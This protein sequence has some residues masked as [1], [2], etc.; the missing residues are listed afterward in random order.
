MIVCCNKKLRIVLTDNHAGTAGRKLCFSLNFTKDRESVFLIA[1]H[2]CNG[3]DR[4][5]SILCHLRNRLAV[6]RRSND[7][8]RRDST[9]LRLLDFR[10]TALLLFFLLWLPFLRD[11]INISFL[12]NI[13]HANHHPA[14]NQS[15]EQCGKNHSNYSFHD[16][17]PF[18]R[19]NGI[20]FLCQLCD[21]SKINTAF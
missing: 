13:I 15:K 3:N 5:H 16:T 14:C 12:C 10:R 6:S 1:H 9:L 7:C 17:S 20:K 21:L 11:R 8:I 2:I 4:R 18:L 19:A